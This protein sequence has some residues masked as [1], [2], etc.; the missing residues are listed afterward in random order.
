M[1]LKEYFSFYVSGTLLSDVGLVSWFSGDHLCVECGTIRYARLDGVE[2][3]SPV[4]SNEDVLPR[5]ESA[6]RTYP[7]PAN[8]N[9]TLQFSILES[10]HIEASVYDLKGALV[11]T[12]SLG[13][14]SG[15]AEMR[16]TLDTSTWP[17]GLYQIRIVGDRG[18][19]AT[20][21]IIVIH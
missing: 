8:R 4:V 20:K 3:G 16:N 21:G 9:V 18:F 7:N 14:V 2:Y 11:E 17:S 19:N 6:I 10:Q 5:P 12:R 15:S 1:T 13:I